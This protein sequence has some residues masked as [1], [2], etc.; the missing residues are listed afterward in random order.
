M[1]TRPEPIEYYCRDILQCAWWLL[2]QPAYEE[3]LAY[4]PGRH[5]NDAGNEFTARCTRRTGGGS[6]RF[7]RLRAVQPT[8]TVA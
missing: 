8:L 6:S 3:H 1:R 5:F 4:A 2:Q 7:V